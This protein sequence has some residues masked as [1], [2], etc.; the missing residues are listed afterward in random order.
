MTVEAFYPSAIM[1]TKMLQGKSEF[2][3]VNPR[4]S[5]CVGLCPIKSGPILRFVQVNMFKYQTMDLCIYSRVGPEFESSRH[6]VTCL[7]LQPSAHKL[8]KVCKL[9]QI[10]AHS[11]DY[12][13]IIS[14]LILKMR[15]W[16]R[17]MFFGIFLTLV[18]LLIKIQPARPHTQ[19][20]LTFALRKELVLISNNLISVMMVVASTISFWLNT[21]NSSIIMGTFQQIGAK[22]FLSGS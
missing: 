5:K 4:W 13:L 11:L 16:S 20:C 18:E 21:K 8:G 19:V 1:M 12:L 9:S 3:K 7:G 14:L 22:N 2:L 15:S 6:L 17:P 10:G